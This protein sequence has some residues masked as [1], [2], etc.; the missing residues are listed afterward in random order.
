LRQGR[1]DDNNEATAVHTPASSTAGSDEDRAASRLNDSNNSHNTEADY[2]RAKK[3][4]GIVVNERNAGQIETGDAH[5]YIRDEVNVQ[6]AKAEFADLQK[7]MSRKG[8]LYRQQSRASS[9]GQKEPAFDPEK[10]G[11]VGEEF[12]LL[13]FLVSSLLS[14][15]SQ[16][17]PLNSSE[18]TDH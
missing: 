15:L 6:A 5:M 4:D 14:R 16:S 17:L 13:D 10:G 18:F 1:A 11:D 9:K 8:S 7:K 2:A 12:D 3:Q